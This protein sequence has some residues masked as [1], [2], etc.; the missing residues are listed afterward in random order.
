MGTVGRGAAWIGGAIDQYIVDGA[1]NGLAIGIVEGG[2]RL[3]RVQ[4]GR[5]NNYVLG[6]AV[7]IF[8][9]IVLTTWL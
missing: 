9:L 8:I 2:R 6:V 5:I 1:V 4:T 3:R 7:G